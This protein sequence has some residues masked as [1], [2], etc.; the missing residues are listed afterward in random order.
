MSPFSVAPALNLAGHLV[1]AALYAMLAALVV[2]PP[3]GAARPSQG[4][5][6]RQGA[7]LPLLTGLLGLVWNVGALASDLYGLAG[8]PVPGWVAAAAFSALGFLPAATVYAVVRADSRPPHA[9][10]MATAGAAVALAALAAARHARA[11]LAGGA[12]PDPQGMLWLTVGTSS[13]LI[14]LLAWTRARAGTR[15]PWVLALAIFAVSGFHLTD[16]SGRES[17]WIALV[18]H[19]ASLPLALAILHQEY[20]FAFA[21]VFLKRALAVLSLAGALL[22][23]WLAAVSQWP[24]RAWGL[25]DPTTFLAWLALGWVAAVAYAPLRRVAARLVDRHVL[26]RQDPARQR[27]TLA[28]R[29]AA[30]EVEAEAVDA[31]AGAV[32]TALDARVVGVTATQGPAAPPESTPLVWLPPFP[33]GVEVPPATAVLLQLPTLH[34]PRLRVTAGEL[35]HG[36]RVWSDDLDLLEELAGMAARRVDAIRH[37]TQRVQQAVRDQEVGR[38]VVEAELR[39]LRA[40]LHP[41]FLFNALN[42][43][44]YLIGAAPERADAVLMQLTG[45]LRA[46]LHRSADEFTTLGDELELVRSYLAIEQARF[47]TRLRATIDVPDDVMALQVPALVLQPLVENAV[48]HGIGPV[49]RGGE[50]R[51]EGAFD[52]ERG[53]LTLVVA[54]SG[55]GATPEAFARDGGVGLASVQRRLAL[56]YGAGAVLGIDS[57]PGLGTVITLTFPSHAGHGASAGRHA[58][59]S[60]AAT[61]PHMDLPA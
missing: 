53:V 55:A 7:R 31:L 19:H 12:V 48:R 10:G 32:R 60:S 24:D 6:W 38:H 49:R 23:A 61:V 43:V 18:G 8:L 52:Q 46:V 51:V 41:H 37:E 39:A 1:G 33:A 34:A 16:H 40:Q 44:R 36:R 58:T 42:T 2:A 29:L 15:S 56:H 5:W 21:D 25:Q 35:Q 57:T 30:T 47:E 14:V 17:W 59:A 13:L 4:P 26:G 22:L 50:V 28:G 45:V 3:A 20:R 54:D 9:F 27:E 11:A